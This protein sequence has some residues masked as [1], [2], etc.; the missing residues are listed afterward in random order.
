MHF[1]RTKASMLAIVGISWPFPRSI[2]ESLLTWQGSFLGTKPKK[3]WMTTLLCIGLDYLC[4]RNKNAFEKEEISDHRIKSS[5]FVIYGLGQ[6]CIEVIGIVL[7]L[8]F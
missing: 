8:M 6:M 3:T 4:E 5:L 2:R 1:N 7:C